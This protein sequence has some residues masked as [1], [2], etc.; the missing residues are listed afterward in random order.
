MT[1]ASSS[2]V[3]LLSARD[4][5]RAL[6]GARQQGADLIVA[7]RVV[8]HEQHLSAGQVVTPASCARILVSRDLPGVDP[9]GKQQGGKRIGGSH[10]PLARGMRMQ[11]HEDLTIGK[12]RR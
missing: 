5:G 9:G 12:L 3:S 1:V 2:A 7:G 6:A 8:K 10:G 4:Q 11:G